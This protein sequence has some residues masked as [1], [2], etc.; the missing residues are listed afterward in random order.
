MKNNDLAVVHI[1]FSLKKANTFLTRLKGLMFR[2]K[3]LNEEVLWIIPCNSIHMCFMFF[4]IDA[5][6][7]DKQNRIAHLV[8]NLQPWRLVLPVASAHS[9][10]E[11]P[12]GTIEKLELK[13]HQT[14]DL[15]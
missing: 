2:K 13:L 3:P 9:V 10:I 7:L 11:L 1:P 14:L 12:S 4:P 15:S 8:E 5:V 6:F